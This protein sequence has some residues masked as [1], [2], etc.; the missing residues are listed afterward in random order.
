MSAPLSV[1]RRVISVAFLVVLGPGWRSA[2][3][4]AAAIRAGL[5]RDRRAAGR[6][7]D[8][9]L[10]FPRLRGGVGPLRPLRPALDRRRG[11]Q[12]AG[13]ERLQGSLEGGALEP[14]RLGRGQDAQIGT[15]GGGG[16]QR[17]LG[18][19]KLRHGLGLQERARGRRGLALA[20]G[21]KPRRSG[22]RRRR[23]VAGAGDT[24][25][26]DRVQVQRTLGAVS[27][28]LFFGPSGLALN[29]V[30]TTENIS[31]LKLR[32]TGLVD[33]RYSLSLRAELV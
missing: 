17:R 32:N 28:E 6:G 11:D 3:G 12:A 30:A 22:R 4:T 7:D 15:G 31:G 16:E 26:L 27:H 8:Q 14:E 10:A 18:V 13:A 19:G 29:I 2:A 1:E 5:C 23:C 33:E 9:A 24:N 21:P 25:A 20:E